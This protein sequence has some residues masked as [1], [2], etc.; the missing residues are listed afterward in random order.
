MSKDLLEMLEELHE[1]KQRYVHY[2]EQSKKS[3]SQLTMTEGDTDC[4]E[5]IKL[6]QATESE[7]ETLQKLISYID[8]KI[9]L[10]R[11]K[12]YAS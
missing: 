8:F 5:T 6:L 10:L 9:K 7:V 3:L 1:D 4:A 11:V 12:E 2:L